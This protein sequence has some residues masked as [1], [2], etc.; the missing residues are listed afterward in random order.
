MSLISTIAWEFARMMQGGDCVG[1]FYVG[2]CCVSVVNS[3][4]VLP[5]FKAAWPTHLKIHFSN[6]QLWNSNTLIDCVCG[7]EGVAIYEIIRRI[8]IGSYIIVDFS[9]VILASECRG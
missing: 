5:V 4:C 9:L 3:K 6:L 8:N 7:V 1:T 2:K